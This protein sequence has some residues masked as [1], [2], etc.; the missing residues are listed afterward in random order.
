MKFQRALSRLQQ[1]YR[2]KLAEGLLDPKVN[3]EIVAQAMAEGVIL[4]WRGISKKSGESVA[5][6][7][8]AA[9]ELLQRDPDFRDWVSDVAMNMANF[10]EEEVQELGNG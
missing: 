3:Q 6:S 4:N 9:A 7:K 2:K 5:Y 10:R 8:E 1:P